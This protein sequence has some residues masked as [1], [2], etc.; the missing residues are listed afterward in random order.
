MYHSIKVLLVLLFTYTR[1]VSA[2]ELCENLQKN[3]GAFTKCSRVSQEVKTHCIRLL[4]EGETFPVCTLRCQEIL[5]QALVDRMG[6][7]YINCDCGQDVPCH[8]F[9]ARFKR[10]MN[11]SVDEDM[12]V[13]CT[14]HLTDCMDDK[15]CHQL[16]GNW[17]DS[18]RDLIFG[19]TCNASCINA[20][21]ELHEH[22]LGINLRTCECDG[23]YVHDRFCREV[24]FKHD[25]FCREERAQKEDFQN[26]SSNRFHTRNLLS[27]QILL[28]VTSV[29]LFR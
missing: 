10:C 12:K 3:C 29:M 4:V 27:I 17:F 6:Q 1:L 5:T 25:N 11:A 7:R 20:R 16:Y 14:K 8:I 21:R 18:C 9:R 24:R 22:P 26:S 19:D 15:S 13:S 2:V 28:L 23:K